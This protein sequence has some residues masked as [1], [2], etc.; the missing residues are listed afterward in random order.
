M[1][2]IYNP[3]SKNKNKSFKSTVWVYLDFTRSFF[4]LQNLLDPFKRIWIT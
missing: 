4:F 1:I 2:K 3:T